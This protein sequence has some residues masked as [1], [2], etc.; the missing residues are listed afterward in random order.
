MNV[1]QDGNL[2]FLLDSSKHAQAFRQA[3][4]AIGIERRS[5]RLVVRGLEDE[6]DVQ[7]GRD[8]RQALGH[9]HCVLFTLNDA[10]SGNDRQR[11]ALA[12]LQFSNAYEPSHFFSLD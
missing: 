7:L 9:L 3:R 5:V 6:G 2:K 4:P 8:C 1:G 12:D 10:G 11:L